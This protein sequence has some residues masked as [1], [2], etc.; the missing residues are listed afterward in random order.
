[1]VYITA[2]DAAQARRIGRDLVAGRLAACANILS[3]MRS[4]YFWK[5]RPCDDREAVLI[6]KTRAALLEKLVKRVKR[7]HSYDIPCIV[8]WPIAGGNREFL[9]WIEKETSAGKP[10]DKRRRGQTLTARP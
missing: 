9:R 10:P 4:L 2:R 5:G 7:L 3:G 1:M 8:A 6:V